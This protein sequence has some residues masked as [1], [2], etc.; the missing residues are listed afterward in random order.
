MS[1]GY[2]DKECYKCGKR[3]W[4]FQKQGKLF[5]AT[6]DVVVLCHKKCKE[7]EE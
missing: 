4:F 5:H 3:V 7:I 2:I 6:P 1:S